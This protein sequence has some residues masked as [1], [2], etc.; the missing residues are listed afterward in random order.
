MSKRSR[1]PL[2]TVAAF[3]AGVAVACAP[4]VA[5]LQAHAAAARNYWLLSSTGQ[6]FAYG[7]A[8]NYGGEYRKHYKGTLTAIKGTA[9]GKGY[10]IITTKTHYSF[11]DGTRYRYTKGGTSRYTGK[12]KPKGLRGKIISIATAKLAGKPTKTT[13]TTTT[14]TKPTTTTT[15]PAPD[16]STVAIDLNPTTH[17]VTHDGTAFSKPLSATGPSGTWSWAVSPGT[18]PGSTNLSTLPAGLSL[19]TDGVVSGTPTSNGQAGWV[20]IRATDSACPS[21]A[22]SVQ[23][24]FLI[25]DPYLAITTTSLA[26]GQA[27]V[28]YSQTMTSTGGGTITNWSATGLPIG[29]SLS[30]SGELSGTPADGDAPSGPTNYTVMI[31]ATD[32]DGQVPAVSQTYNLTIS[33]APLQFVTTT[34]T[35]V[36]GEGFS[37]SIVMDG[38]VSPY[39]LSLAAGST[40]PTGLTFDNGTI[41]GTPTAATGT[42]TF[43]VDAA[44]SQTFPYENSETFTM[45]IAPGGTAPNTTISSTYDANIWDGYVEQASSGGFTSVSGTLTVPDLM[46]ADTDN[47][48]SPWVGIGGYGV[49]TLLQAG[50]SAFADQST[51]VITYEG[52]WENAS[53]NSPQDLITVEPGDTISVYIWEI[54]SG[55]WELT[56]NDLTNGQGFAVQ[57]AYSGNT[58]TAE[59]VVE[60]GQGQPAVGY[61]STSTFS[62]LT[63]SQAGSGVIETTDPGGSPGSLSSGGFTVS[64]GY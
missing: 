23:Q 47:E 10:W 38:G 24:F 3:S 5:A 16:C 6:V 27:T 51:G 18:T 34:L 59:W 39:T 22:V 29:L 11:G 41:S 31:T 2:V 61:T 26:S 60:E 30:T 33:P 8:H 13:T 40:M 64:T 17:I 46:N 62:N 25:E 48:V 21:D 54:S 36:E 52:W 12:T 42:Y 49:N 15:T 28:A 20:T 63:A 53:V 35:A 57:D 44:D 32:A 1:F 56:L 45:A 58:A 9:D 7:K 4:A 19:S 14:Q 37:G 43:T 50:V 55:E